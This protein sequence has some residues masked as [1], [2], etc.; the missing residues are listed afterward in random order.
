MSGQSPPDPFLVLVPS[1]P[2]SGFWSRM[3]EILG[4][5]DPRGLL[6]EP[7]SPRDSE[8]FSISL[9][10]LGAKLAK[11]DGRITR[12][13]VRMFRAIVE[14]PPGEERH[15]ARVFDLCGRETTGY[16]AYARKMDR[17]LGSGEEADL[18]RRD[19]LDMLFHIAMADEEYHPEEKIFLKKVAEIFRISEPEFEALEARHV[20]DIW[21]PHLVLGIPH[22]ADADAV[23]LARRRIA[24]ESHPDIMAARGMPAEMVALAHARLSDANR[25]A[26]ELVARLAAKRSDRAPGP[27]MSS[28]P[29]W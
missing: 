29:G 1:P 5:L 19:V 8:A 21:S 4:R 12:D 3:L 27:E 9:I 20:P 24:R 14:I 13:E 22:D 25:A 10:A 23:R 17:S 26:D 11:A 28:A 7:A 18:I 2:P 16:E 6:R 15:A